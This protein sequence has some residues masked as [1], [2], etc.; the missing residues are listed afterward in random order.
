MACA[1][2]GL[3]AVAVMQPGAAPTF[4]W[5]T[6]KPTVLYALYGDRPEAPHNPVPEA[7]DPLFRVDASTTVTTT[8]AEPRL[9]RYGGSATTM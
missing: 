6:G 4:A 3:A 9:Y 2:C 7:A 1:T 5:H 8:R